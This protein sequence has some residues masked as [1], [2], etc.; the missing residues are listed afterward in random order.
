M[1]RL[2]HHIFPQD[3][4]Q[5]GPPIAAARIGRAPRSLQLDIATRAVS[6]NRLAQQDR[7]PI[8]KLRIVVAKL[9]PGIKLR[10]GRGP[11]RHMV[12]RKDLCQLGPLAC[13]DAQLRPKRSVIGQQLRR[14]D[15]H[16]GLFRVEHRRQRG[17]CI[18]KGDMQCHG[19]NI[20]GRYQIARA[21]RQNGART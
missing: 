17:I 3:R 15:R 6:A 12:A 2:A 9:M 18:V 11:L 14:L 5:P 8:A 20:C 7:A 10:Q 21:N 19:P 1:H 16:R 13:G 4:P